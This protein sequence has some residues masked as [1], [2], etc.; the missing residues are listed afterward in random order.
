MPCPTYDS[1]AT[2]IDI[3]LKSAEADFVCVEAVSTA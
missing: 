1:S 3:I 2:G